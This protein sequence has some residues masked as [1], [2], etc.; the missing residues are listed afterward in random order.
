MYF[1]RLRGKVMGPFGDAQLVSL[2]DRGQLKPFHEVSTDKVLWVPASTLT[3]IFPT[4]SGS[5]QLLPDTTPN[6]TVPTSISCPVGESWFWADEEGNRHG[7]FEIGNFKSLID[8]GRVSAETLVWK[9]GMPDWLPADQVLP[10]LFGPKPSGIKSTKDLKKQGR[11]LENLKKTRL[12]ILLIL[13]AGLVGLL[14]FPLDPIAF[15]LGVIGLGFCMAA[16]SPAKGPATLTFYFCMA[17]GLLWLLWFVIS[18]F[19]W[20]LL[21]DFVSGF[22][23][24]IEGNKNDVEAAAAGA[25]AASLTFLGFLSF[26]FMLALGMLFTCGGFLQ[27]T[28]RKLAIVTGDGAIIKLS[29]VNFIIYCVLSGLLVSFIYLL[30]LIPLLYKNGFLLFNPI[31]L[32]KIIWTIAIIESFIALCIGVCYIITLIIAMQLYAKFGKMTEIDED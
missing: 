10:I 11:L 1:V 30:I 32:P 29:S 2:R 31:I 27:H 23:Q 12:G 13:I 19:G 24:A 28:L 8:S 7:P 25:A 5:E 6:K 4:Q 18:I 15:V 22:Y 9:S 3:T 20:Q 16:P 26:T 14:C 17:T 21:I